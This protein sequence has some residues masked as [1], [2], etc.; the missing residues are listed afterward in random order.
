M[1]IYGQGE[2][3][4]G[5]CLTLISLVKKTLLPQAGAFFNII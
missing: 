3:D 2:F 5:I 1:G 4:A